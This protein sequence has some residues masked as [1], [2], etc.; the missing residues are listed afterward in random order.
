MNE[1]TKLDKQDILDL[2]GDPRVLSKSYLALSQLERMLKLNNTLKEAIMKA[3]N[4][5]IHAPFTEEQVVNLN[6][7]QKDGRFHP[8]T[9]GSG[10]HKTQSLI[11]GTSGWH[12][13]LCDYK[14]TWAHEFMGEPYMQQ[15][16]KLNLLAEEPTDDVPEIV[17]RVDDILKTTWK[18]AWINHR[19][20][21]GLKLSDA[22][23][24]PS[25]G[26]TISKIQISNKEDLSKLNEFM[27]LQASP[28]TEAG[29]ARYRE[30]A[31]ELAS[32]D[33][34]DHGE[35]TLEQAVTVLNEREHRGRDNWVIIAVDEDS[36]PGSEYYLAFPVRS[37]ND[38]AIIFYDEYNLTTFEAIALAEKYMR[39]AK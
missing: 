26:A 22:N 28:R 7:W 19:V 5:I 14:Q 21:F 1:K 36:D 8:F 33:D 37:R 17:K 39:E 27:F 12:C 11:A 20:K 18:P 15:P 16:I 31:K 38:N 3:S 6:N 23:G 29:E 24:F 30:L 13:P 34:D 2:F 35:M 10:Q 32:D 25:E 4:N 9:C